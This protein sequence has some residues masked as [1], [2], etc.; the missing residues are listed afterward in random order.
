MKRPY[1]IT[2]DGTVS[3]DLTEDFRPF[4][5]TFREVL[6]SLDGMDSF[7]V[8]LWPLP[9]G[10]SSTA[11]LEPA[12]YSEQ[13][14]QCA[15]SADRM[16]IEVRVAFE[17]TGRLFTLGRPVRA[18]SVQTTGVRWRGQE[19]Q[20]HDNEVFEYQEASTIFLAYLKSGATPSTYTLRGH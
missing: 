19:L 12:G 15:G 3:M 9:P 18:R 11:D 14:L 17:G 13:F 20:V 7:A 10:V 4:N 16:T 5:E 2:L 8:S 1:A 6:S